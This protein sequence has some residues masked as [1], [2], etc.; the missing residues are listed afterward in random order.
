MYGVKIEKTYVL[1][2]GSRHRVGYEFK[3]I[4]RPF[5]DFMNVYNVFLSM[6]NG[7]IPDPPK[8]DKYPETIKIINK[9]EII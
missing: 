1:R 3:E 7:K 6:N 4:K 5:S 2:I 8:E 9:E